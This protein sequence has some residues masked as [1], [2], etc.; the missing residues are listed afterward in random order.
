M[1]FEI[2]TKSVVISPSQTSFFFDDPR[3]NF[4]RCRLEKPN[5]SEIK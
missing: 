4:G 5:I 2:E 1:E 3:C